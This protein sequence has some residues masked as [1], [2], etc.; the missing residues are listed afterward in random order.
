LRSVRGHRRRVYRSPRRQPDSMQL[1]GQEDRQ[2]DRV[3]TS[4]RRKKPKDQTIL[5]FSGTTPAPD[6]SPG[7]SGP[8][9]SFLADGGDVT[10]SS[11]PPRYPLP[12]NLKV[13]SMTCNL[14]EGDTP[15]PG[16]S[17]SCQL[18]KNGVPVSGFVIVY[19][20]GQT[21]VKTFNGRPVSFSPGDTLGLAVTEDP[22]AGGR[23]RV[24]AMIR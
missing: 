1:S 21:G 15:P 23:L 10:A 22:C 20:A 7:W 5:K 13:R 11:T 2:P 24:S 12:I 19:A 3:M 8:V 14:L 18:V 4:K 17:F 9:T 6:W 16:S